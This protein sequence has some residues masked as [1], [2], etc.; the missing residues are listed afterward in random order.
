MPIPHHR[1]QFLPLRISFLLPTVPTLPTSW[2][3]PKPTGIPLGKASHH[4]QLHH[5]TS[6][7]HLL[8]LLFNCPWKVSQNLL[9][10]LAWSTG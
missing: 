3:G 10:N 1:Q 4:H 7:L 9:T 2:S 8:H 5:L 6:H